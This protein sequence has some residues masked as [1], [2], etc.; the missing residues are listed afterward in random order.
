VA[1]KVKRRVKKNVK[2]IKKTKSYQIL[3]FLIVLGVIVFGYLFANDMIDL[4]LFVPIDHQTTQP[5]PEYSA[6]QNELGFYYYQYADIGDYYEKANDLQGQPLLLELRSIINEGY[7]A[8]RYEDAKTVLAEADLSLTDLT[9]V[10]NI[11]TGLL[12][13]ATWDSTS[14]HREHVWP[15]SRL[16]IP[17]VTAS[18][19]NQ[20]SDLHNLRA[21]TPSVN[22]S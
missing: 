4:S 13:D 16:G 7:I 17:R 2:K 8:P 12:V 22:S 10:F 11:Y 20:G 5:T 19:R 18:S 3:S 6:S 21:I 14:W 15:N 1:K 9:K